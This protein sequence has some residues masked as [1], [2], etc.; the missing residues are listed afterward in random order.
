MQQVQDFVNQFHVWLD[1]LDYEK[2]IFENQAE[3]YAEY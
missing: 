1:Q 2:V 3:S